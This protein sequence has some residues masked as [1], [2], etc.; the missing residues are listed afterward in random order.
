VRYHATAETPTIIIHPN[1]SYTYGETVPTSRTVRH[2]AIRQ[3]L[4]I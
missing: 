3:R 4:M 1:K 2:L